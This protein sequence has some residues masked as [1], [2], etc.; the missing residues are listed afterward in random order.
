MEP[1]D[2]QA[3]ARF[4][5]AFDG[6]LRIRSPI[7]K[8]IHG[9][10]QSKLDGRPMPPRDA[11]DPLELGRLLPYVALADVEH[12]PLRLRWRLLGTHITRALGRDSTGRYFDEIYPGT[13]YE[14]V[15]T[16]YRR[17]LEHRRPVRHFG[18]PT[19]F[20]RAFASYE[21]VHLP[22]SGDGAVIDMILVGFVFER[23]LPEEK[24]ARHQFR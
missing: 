17:V 15:M 11:L 16:V 12:D 13:L 5:P 8:A 22:L 21:S 19:F 6:E 1:D 3:E 24:G 2:K 7:L 18:Q 23:D 9:Y 14:D 4:A 20:N 10:W